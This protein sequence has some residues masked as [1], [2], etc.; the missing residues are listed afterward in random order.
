[1]SN[2]IIPVINPAAPN[3]PLA[4]PQY[5]SRYQDQLNNVLRLYF[6]RLQ[7]GQQQLIEQVASNQ[8]LAWMGNSG[9][10]FSG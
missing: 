1:M 5:E 4:T 9:G 7:N 10:M 8:T 2:Y 3:L 6:N